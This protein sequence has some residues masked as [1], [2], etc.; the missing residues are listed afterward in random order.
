MMAV[1]ALIPFD[2]NFQPNWV[3]Y[4]AMGNA[5]AVFALLAGVGLSLTS[6]RA[7]VPRARAA[8][9]IA[10]VT[11]R[12]AVIGLVGL[13]L[14]YTDA[15]IAGVILPYYALLF[16]L[17]IPLL[18]LRTRALVLVGILAAVMVPVISQ[19]IRPALPEA[20]LENPSFV[21]LFDHPLDLLSELLVTGAIRRCPGC[22]TSAPA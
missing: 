1:H 21:Y 20:T 19:L 14:G 17:A 10:S 18:F 8:T 16:V 13:L 5:S 22:R 15:E 11:G 4:V 12:A 7:V 9:T 3:T 2:V 6:G